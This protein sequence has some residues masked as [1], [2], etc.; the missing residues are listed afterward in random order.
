MIS[1]EILFR[2]RH[3]RIGLYAKYSK[4]DYYLFYNHF[5]FFLT[6]ISCYDNYFG[7]VDR[8]VNHFINYT[9]VRVLP[10]NIEIYK[11]YYIHY[12]QI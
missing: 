4:L 9:N 10:N 6:I 3:C 1:I 2:I 5:D 12:F 7:G 11:I 8:K